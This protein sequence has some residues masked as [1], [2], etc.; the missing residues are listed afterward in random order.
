MQY[1]FMPVKHTEDSH[2]SQEGKQQEAEF[3]MDALGN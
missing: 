3:Q 1:R 2:R